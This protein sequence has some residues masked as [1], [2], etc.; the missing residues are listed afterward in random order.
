[1]I[2]VRLREAVIAHTKPFIPKEDSHW[3][4][5]CTRFFDPKLRSLAYPG[6]AL[7]SQNRVVAGRID[8]RS[9]TAVARSTSR[10]WDRQWYGQ[11]FPE[12]DLGYP[13]F[14]SRFRHPK[15]SLLRLSQY[16]GAGFTHLAGG[17]VTFGRWVKKRSAA[18]EGLHLLL[19]GG[20]ALASRPE[21]LDAD[22]SSSSLASLARFLRQTATRRHG[23]YRDKCLA[24][25]NRSWPRWC[26][27]H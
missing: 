27:R 4:E 2:C 14:R 1:M 16:N 17:M 9:F 18:R 22:N 23:L 15:S 24:G 6:S 19:H 7:L 21:S 5:G 3:I 13:G 10:R 11:D 12:G 26:W 8:G 25:R 20:M